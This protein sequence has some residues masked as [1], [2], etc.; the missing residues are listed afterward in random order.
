MNYVKKFLFLFLICSFSSCENETNLGEDIERNAFNALKE[1]DIVRNYNLRKIAENLSRSKDSDVFEKISTTALKKYD[2][3]NNF[4]YNRDKKLLKKESLNNLE[5]D[6]DIDE[7]S[8]PYLNIYVYKPYDKTI[9][10]L[11]P[12]VFYF[13]VG[14]KDTEVNELIG[15]FNGKEIKIDAQNPPINIENPIFV[16]G[17]NERIHEIKESN[18]VSFS[19]KNKS[20]SA[21]EAY[22]DVGEY[23]DG[24]GSTGGGTNTSGEM[25]VTYSRFLSMSAKRFYEPWGKGDAEVRFIFTKSGYIQRS[26]VSLNP[27]TDLEVETSTAL[28]DGGYMRQSWWNFYAIDNDKQT[29][30]FVDFTPFDMGDW[31]N[32]KTT[33]Y[34]M[35]II[36]E[37]KYWGW[38]GWLLS[39]TRNTKINFVDFKVV[40]LNNLNIT[41]Q[42]I[43]EPYIRTIYNSMV[44]AN[45]RDTFMAAFNQLKVNTNFY[46]NTSANNYINLETNI[47]TSLVLA[48]VNV[49][50]QVLLANE[51]TDDQIGTDIEIINQNNKLYYS[52][53]GKFEFKLGY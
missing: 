46:F 36:E 19:V 26:M 6:V 32:P 24:G 34:S 12:Y 16:I 14:Q 7:L 44:N 39:E 35:R 18:D 47:K 2:G 8:N 40:F 3:D 50:N 20:Y 49:L 30:P 21:K 4:I 10:N 25:K 48:G 38:V 5:K 33:V 28:I 22:F 52:S 42:N 17:E 43:V 29:A 9:D 11:K 1:S 13:P 31:R 51:N 53:D 41:P 37:D 27:I 45:D 23:N 15:F